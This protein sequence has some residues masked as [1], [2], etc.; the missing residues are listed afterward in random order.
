MSLQ[1]SLKEFQCQLALSVPKEV[2]EVLSRSTSLLQEQ[3]LAEGV[4]KEGDIFPAFSLPDSEGITH[5]LASLLAKGPII[6]SFYRGGWC[7]YCVMELKALRAIIEQLPEL[8]ATLVAISPETSKHSADTKVRNDLNFMIL[9]DKDNGL[10]RECGLVFKI[11]P[12]LLTQYQNFGFDI[13]SHNGNDKFELPIPATYIVD[14][15][16]VIRFA[17]VE[18]DY[19]CRVEPEKL[20]G[21]LKSLNN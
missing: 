21:I 19:T 3:H 18:E 14:Q 17:F 10:A 16:G 4:S 20:L 8:G 2:L 6:V 5:D 9:S 7:P 12:D 15:Q 1:K 11:P 13:E